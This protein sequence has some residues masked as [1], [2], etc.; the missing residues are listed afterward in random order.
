MCASTHSPYLDII[1]VKVINIV[2]F[3]CVKTVI[4]TISS[5]EK[6]QMH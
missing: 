4:N 2:L 6:Q 3:W 5:D 1:K